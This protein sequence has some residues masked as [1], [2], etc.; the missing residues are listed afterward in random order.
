MIKT[1]VKILELLCQEKEEIE[2]NQDGDFVS[3]IKNLKTISGV[4]D[5]TIATILGECEDLI[6]IAKKIVA[7]MYSIFKYNQPCNPTRV[8]LP[9]RK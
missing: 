5:K 6:I 3:S 1:N 7:I 8:L 2:D 4:A 9:Y